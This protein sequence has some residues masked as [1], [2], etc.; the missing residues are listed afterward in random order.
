MLACAARRQVG[1]RGQSR[2]VLIL[3]ARTLLRAARV[4]RANRTCACI[5]AQPAD[6]LVLCCVLAVVQATLRD[7]SSILMTLYSI[8]AWLA[9]NPVATF[10][11]H[12][13][14]IGWD[15]AKTKGTVL[16]SILPRSCRTQWLKL[17]IK[18]LPLAQPAAHTAHTSST[19]TR[20]GPKNSKET[21]AEQCSPLWS[22]CR[23]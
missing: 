4:Q 18:I 13:P 20:S 22:T 19:R 12:F 14:E 7:V 9:K 2:R 15:S 17:M 10:G 6:R 11:Q 23:E 16:L 1:R 3:R 5:D 21:L 8:L